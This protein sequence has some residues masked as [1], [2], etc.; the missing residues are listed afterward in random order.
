[1]DNILSILGDDLHALSSFRL[2]Q[3]SAAN[4]HQPNKSALNL[5]SGQAV[6]M[7]LSSLAQHAWLAGTSSGTQQGK[8]WEPMHPMP[9]M[10]RH[11]MR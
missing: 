1:M 6:H 11:M 9:V 3:F 2:Y 5:A 10:Q 7:G 4:K 8:S